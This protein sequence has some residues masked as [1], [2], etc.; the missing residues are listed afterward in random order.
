MSGGRRLGRLLVAVVSG[1]LVGALVSAVPAG[2]TDLPASSSPLPGSQF[3]GADGDE[4][5][6]S[7]L[8]DEQALQAAGRLGHSADANDRDS[9]FA[10]GSK[11]DEPGKWGLTSESNGVNPGKAN[12][13]DAWSAVDQP[14][15]DAFVYLAFVRAAGDGTT[16]LAFELNQDAR[17]WDN[18][19]ARIPCRRSGDVLVSY[20]PQG[21]DVDVVIQ[22]W[23]TSQTDPGT[24]CARSG[25]LEDFTDFEPN[26][27]VQGAMNQAQI[28]H[29]LPGAV[30]APGVVPK[31]QF[32]EAALNLSKLLEEA[33]G[34]ECLSFR[35]VWMHS[36]S[37]TSESSNMQDYVA[38]RPLAAATCAA[39][40][41]KFFDSNAN[42]VRDAGEPGI[43]GFVIF[44]DYDNDAHRDAGEPF[45]VS[46]RRGAYV[47]Y[48]I[49]PPAGTYTLREE[50]P[51]RVAQAPAA[52]SWICSYPNDGTSGGFGRPGGG[53]STCGWRS[54]DA[55]KTPNAQG[56]DFGNYLPARLIVNKELEPSGDPG[57]FDL[58]VNGQVVLAG[59][60]DGASVTLTVP[61]G[62]YD[63]TEV[64]AAETNAG[65][66]RSIVECKR[67]VH[68][69]QLRAGTVWNDLTL[70]AGAR[71]VCTFRNIRPLAPAIAIDKT[72]PSAVVA[73]RTLNY[74]LY[75]TNP[76]DV[77]VPQG[78]VRV[79]DPQCDA[80]PRLEAKAGASGPDGSPATLD[81]GDTWTYACTHQTAPP[82]ARCRPSVLRNTATASGTIGPVTVTD[83]DS[84]ATL[85]I[86][87]RQP[88]PPVVT[89]LGPTRPVLPGAP[90]PAPSPPKP[91]VPPHPPGP[92]PP[93]TPEP[94]GM[95]AQAGPVAPSGPPPPTAGQAGVASVT[96]R[97][98]CLTGLQNAQAAGTRISQLRISVDG[99]PFRRVD[100]Q[101]LQRRAS[102][103][104]AAPS[105]GRHRLTI[106]VSFQPGSGTPPVT[107]TRNIGVCSR[108]RPNFTG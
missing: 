100:L 60:G 92:P 6:A 65:D 39:S 53:L 107:L 18:G 36:R 86:C 79:D 8:V 32:G 55:N 24:G 57:R 44:A 35:S 81:P 62:S 49:R 68:R 3:Q 52:R 105:P 40:G 67:G 11:E 25:R 23:V 71:A 96:V 19:R 95:P 45:T 43:P 2:A 85:V 66:Y 106:R 47:L 72:A 20:Q 26:R 64:A 58:S 9:A 31:G 97:R 69:R 70:P 99:R 5:D 30:S 50:L 38:P 84:T 4:D 56:R 90:A 83:T 88:N 7:T 73:G 78:L 14:G 93:L 82:A 61:P 63:L 101:I 46:D 29:Y 59:A 17:L 1:A 103:P 42:G 77:P 87:P 15:P 10:G 74:A 13:L 76:G 98:G 108:P 104:Q 80:P 91:V 102:L 33:F 28:P 21:N 75:V 51:A 12:I 22:R 48:D 27:D 89:P 37:S 94:P 54:I 34:Q 41:T 16:Y